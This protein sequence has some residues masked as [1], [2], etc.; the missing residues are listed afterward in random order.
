MD[1]RAEHVLQA[2]ALEDRGGDADVRPHELL[3]GVDF[4]GHRHAVR[5][6]E[7][8]HQRVDLDLVQ[9]PLGLVDRDVGLRLRV[10]VCRDDLVPLDAT[11]LVDHVDRNLGRDRGRQRAAASERAGVVVN[12]AELDFLLRGRR[13]AGAR[14]EPNSCCAGRSRPQKPHGVSYSLGALARL[15]PMFRVAR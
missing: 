10:G 5:R 9:E 12:D 11:A 2:L 1:L 7:H 8:A 15:N 4:G 3:G 13:Q 6:R 14:D